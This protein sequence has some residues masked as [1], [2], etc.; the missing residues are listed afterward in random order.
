MAVQGGT[1]HI[2]MLLHVPQKEVTGS[3]QDTAPSTD[4]RFSAPVI[5]Q[6]AT[7]RPT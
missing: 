1:V 6:H 7:Y 4:K 3:A 2:I 5:A